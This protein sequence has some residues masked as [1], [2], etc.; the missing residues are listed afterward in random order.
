LKFISPKSWPVTLISPGIMGWYAWMPF[1]ECYH[2]VVSLDHVIEGA[3]DIDGRTIDFTGGRGYTE[4][5]WGRSFPSSWIW[6]Q[7]NHFS[8]PGSSFTASVAIIPWIGRSFPGFIIGLWHQNKLYRFATYT[9]AKI[10]KLDV[11]NRRIYWVVGDRR[12][13]LEI[14]LDRPDFPAALLHAPTINGMDRRIEERL[15]ASIQLRLHAGKDLIFEE[16]GRHA[17]LEVVGD[18]QRLVAMWEAETKK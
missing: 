1:M 18:T 11:N 8:T 15:D 16:T 7:S 12:H 10:H 3:L 5:D 14:S 2:G 6:L 17:G 13:T 4:K 9:G